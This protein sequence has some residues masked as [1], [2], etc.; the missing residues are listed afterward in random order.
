MAARISGAGIARCSAAGGAHG[1]M[2]W[3]QWRGVAAPG[4]ATWR[5]RNNGKISMAAKY[6]HRH[7]NKRA[8]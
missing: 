4:G 6:R 1:G 7:R 8:K 2:R 5:A 3:Q